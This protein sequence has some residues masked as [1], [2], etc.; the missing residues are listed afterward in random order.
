M[1]KKIV[2]LF[3]ERESPTS[4][5]AIRILV[6]AIMLIDLAWV[7]IFDISGWL[8]APVAEGGISPAIH[9]NPPLIYQWLGQ[10]ASTATIIY[11]VLV[12]TIAMFGVGLFTRPAGLIFVLVY[13]QSAMANDYGDRGIDRAIRVVVLVLAFGAAGRSWSLDAK[14]RT[15]S[16]RGDEKVLAWPRYLVLGQLLLMYCAAGFSKGGTLWFPW[17]GYGALYVILNDPIY[18]VFDFSWLA[19]PVFYFFTQVGTGVTHAWEMS[20]PLVLVAAY[21]RRTEARG[22]RMRRWFAKLRVRDVYVAIGVFFHLS[23]AITMR[24]GIFPWMMLAFFPAFFRPE[25]I[26]RWIA[27]GSRRG[28]RPRSASP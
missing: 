19:H 3:D 5:V 17:G 23:L 6:A 26:E 13:A 25:E 10:T 16:W 18:A 28:Y 9:Q 12:V 2:A 7:G 4:I 27:I 11:V 20:A 1:I 14:R 24:L 21:Y 22:G 15:G 8:W